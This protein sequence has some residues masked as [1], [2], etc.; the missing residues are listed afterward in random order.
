MRKVPTV[1][2]TGESLWNPHECGVE[3]GIAELFTALRLF[4]S[5]VL[6]NI[7]S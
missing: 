6:K 2:H 7:P 1:F 3:H 4:V 5:L